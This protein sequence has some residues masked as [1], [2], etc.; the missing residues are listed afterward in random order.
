MRHHREQ[1]RG[2][3]GGGGGGAYR[4]MR[5]APCEH[6]AK[7]SETSFDPP[8]QQQQ[9]QQQESRL[10]MAAQD[11]QLILPCPVD[12]YMNNLSEEQYRKCVE[13]FMETMERTFAPDVGTRDTYLHFVQ[14]ATDFKQNRIEVAEW[15]EVVKQL[16][17]GHWWLL[18]RFANFLPV[19]DDNIG[20]QLREEAIANRNEET[21][22]QTA[23]MRDAMRYAIHAPHESVEAYH[24]ALMEASYLAR[25][26]PMIIYS[27]V[28]GQYRDFLLRVK[29]RFDQE[30]ADA[31]DDQEAE[32]PPLQRVGNDD[33]QQQQQQQPPL[34]LPR[35]YVPDDDQQPQQQQQ[36]QPL[37][38]QY[39][40]DDDDDDDEEQ[41]HQQPVQYEAFVETVGMLATGERTR[42]QMMEE[43]A[44]MFHP[45][46]QD[47]LYEFYYLMRVQ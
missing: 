11:Q 24:A 31:E 28:T 35:Q 29:D 14:A 1:H 41:P 36:Q 20:D 18:H 3:G 46:H 40:S 25:Y 17:D 47:L 38:R 10:D 12:S 33:H 2:G 43:V 45:E 32:E 22:R 42:R 39:V 15:V 30:L 37:P 7:A 6:K 27:Q 4:R 5:A 34:P 21:L 23:I 19:L 13:N 26:V 9:Q 8:P 16:L 44:M